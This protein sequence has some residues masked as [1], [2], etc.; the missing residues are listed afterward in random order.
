LNQRIGARAPEQNGDNGQLPFTVGV[1]EVDDH[2][3][4]FAFN[5]LL[6]GMVKVELA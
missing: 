2:V 4:C 6:A 5:V 3:V 1:H